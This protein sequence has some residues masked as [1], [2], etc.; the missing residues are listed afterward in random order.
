M[1]ASPVLAAPANPDSIILHTVKVFQNIWETG[2]MLFV[3]SDEPSESAED[4][5]GLAIYDTNGT[6]LIKSRPLNYYQYNVHSVYFNAAQAADLTWGSEYNVRVLG[7]PTF[8]PMTED[9]TMDTTALSS[10]SWLTGT[11]TESQNLLRLH[12]LDLAATLED[13][14][15]IAL[16]TTTPEKQVLN[17]PKL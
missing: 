5:F 11:A 15:V 10:Y 9:I 3:A 1:L 6:T 16:I 4:T 12:C 2:D 14:W 13:E 8:F 7:N 17:I